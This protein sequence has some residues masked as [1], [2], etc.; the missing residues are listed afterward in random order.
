MISLGELWTQKRLFPPKVWAGAKFPC[1]MK[2]GPRPLAGLRVQHVC[3][4]R[5][6]VWTRRGLV[7][8]GNCLPASPPALGL[9]QLVAETPPDMSPRVRLAFAKGSSRTHALAHVVPGDVLG[10]THRD[11]LV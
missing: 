7:T 11:P 9:V 4:P 10:S 3:G 1:G 8:R 5:G 2:T 6:C